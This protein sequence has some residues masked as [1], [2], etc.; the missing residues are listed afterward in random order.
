MNGR[1][2]M[3]DFTPAEAERFAAAVNR[4]IRAQR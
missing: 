2:V 4:A 1:R 3:D